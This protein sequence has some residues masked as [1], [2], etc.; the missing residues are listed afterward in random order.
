MDSLQG[1]TIAIFGD[2]HVCRLQFDIPVNL[3]GKPGEKA[4]NWRQYQEQL[5]GYDIVILMIGGNDIC[6]KD[7]SVAIASELSDL[8][9]DLRELFDFCRN[10]N[11]LVLI[12]DLVPR[13][14]NWS[15]IYKTNSR[16]LKRFKKKNINFGKSITSDDLCDGVHLKDYKWLS[17]LLVRNMAAQ[18]NPSSSS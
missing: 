11:N 15:G 14:S 8:I 13:L 5:V 1:K 9:K 10:E 12:A 18:L 2:S 17:E 3:I 4:Y 7:S 16:L 6:T